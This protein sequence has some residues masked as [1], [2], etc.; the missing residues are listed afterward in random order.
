MVY[1][2]LR[3]INFAHGDV[4]MLGGYFGLFAVTSLIAWHAPP[5]AQAGLGLLIAMVACAVIGVI[6]ERAAY[7]PVRK[8]G[9]LTALI[10]AIGVSLLLENAAQAG[11]GASPR[12]FTIESVDRTYMLSLG[13]IPLIFNQRHVLVFL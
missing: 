6:I 2:V 3:F 9:R 12:A 4:Y 1:G 11:F 13:A 5:L 8:S 10:T 7:K